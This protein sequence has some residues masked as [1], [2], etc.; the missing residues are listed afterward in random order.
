M[1]VEVYIDSNL[2]AHS[3]ILDSILRRFFRT[4][5]SLVVFQ[6]VNWLR[7]FTFFSIAPS[8][9]FKFNPALSLLAFC[10]QTM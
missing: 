5:F 7:F 9:S 8:I 3:T 2:T 6:R 1:R 4:A 10:E